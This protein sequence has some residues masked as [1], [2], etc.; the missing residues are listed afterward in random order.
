MNTVQAWLSDA[1]TMLQGVLGPTDKSYEVWILLGGGLLV[2][3]I[4]MRVMAAATNNT[5]G[6][7]FANAILM[8]VGILIVTLAAVAAQ[9]YGVRD[10]TSPEVARWLPLGAALIAL[11]VLV[12]PLMCL[13]QRVKYLTALVSLAVSVAVAA[14]LI[15]AGHALLKGVG[16]GERVGDAIEKRTNYQDLEKE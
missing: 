7:I 10:T 15:T 1:W 6:G 4:M 14:V 11:F 3:W 5:N 12:V 9:R 16:G 13:L 2:M 8:V